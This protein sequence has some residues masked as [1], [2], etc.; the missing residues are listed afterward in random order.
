MPRFDAARNAKS[1]TSSLMAATKSHAAVELHAAISA[2]KSSRTTNIFAKRRIANT[3]RVPNAP[4]GPRGK[5]MICGPCAKPASKLLWKRA[6]KMHR[7]RLMSCYRIR[8]RRE[9]HSSIFC[10]RSSP[11]LDAIAKPTRR[12]TIS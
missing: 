11:A 7:G 6:R 9:R 4:C 2:R 3:R 10:R 8:A 5:K 1:R 12:S